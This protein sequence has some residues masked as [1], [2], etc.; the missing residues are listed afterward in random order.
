VFW[1]VTESRHLVDII[2]QTDGVEDIDEEDKLGQPMVMLGTQRDWGEVLLY[3]MPYFRKRTFPD[4]NGRLRTPIPVDGEAAKFESGAEEHHLDL[5]VRY[6]HSIG[7][8]DVGT[9]YLYGTSREPVLAPNANGDRLVPFYEL[10][11]QVGTDIQ[12]TREA[13]LWKFEGILREGQGDL[14]TAAVGGFEYTL[15]QILNSTADLGLLLE[16]NWDGRDDFEAPP[17][18]FDHDMFLGSRLAL[19]DVQNT[20]ALLG[21]VVDTDNASTLLFVEAERRLGDSWKVQMEA[22]FFLNVDN[23]DPAVAFKQDN[24]INLIIQRHF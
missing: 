23:T 2:N 13:W 17:T 10:I 21:T 12:F 4:E 14:F 18:I 24:F 19:N 5:A 15:Y 7:D 8:W 3:L 11:H 6:S 16:Y 1:G 22:R 9:Y 20:E